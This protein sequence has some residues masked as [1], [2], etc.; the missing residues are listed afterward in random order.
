[1]TGSTFGGMPIESGMH[2][3]QNGSRAGEGEVE[4][5]LI[6]AALLSV[7]ITRGANPNADM[8]DATTRR[9]FSPGMMSVDEVMRRSQRPTSCGSGGM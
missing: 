6:V 5:E 1:M 8:I 7:S 4:K 3:R 9:W 2:F